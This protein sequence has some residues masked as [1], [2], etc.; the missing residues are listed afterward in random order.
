MDSITRT[1]TSVE[2][3][4]ASLAPPN[5]FPAKPAILSEPNTSRAQPV[6]TALHR[7]SIPALRI[8]LGLVFVW[9]GTLKILGMS[10]IT[11]ILRQTYPFLA[12]PVFTMLLGMWETLIGIGLLF[13]VALRHTLCLMCLHLSGTFLALFLA[14]SLFFLNGN[15]LALTANG[16]FVM[17]NLVLLTAGLVVV[18]NETY[19]SYQRA[20]PVR[21]S[22]RIYGELTK[23]KNGKAELG[24]GQN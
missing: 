2:D 21:V 10:P 11:P 7:W 8:A 22:E 4:T 12:L 5:G 24:I 6:V 17:K 18:G 14:P 20:V 16:E 23:R 9:F 1:Q 13:K 19:L 15:P 3:T